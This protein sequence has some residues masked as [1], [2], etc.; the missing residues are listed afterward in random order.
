MTGMKPIHNLLTLSLS[1]FIMLGAQMVSGQF[2]VHENTTIH[3]DRDVS[4]NIKQNTF[5]SSIYGSA[6]LN[7][8]GDEQQ[9]LYAA[10]DVNL[11]D[12]NVLN[13]E[14]LTLYTTVTING[15]LNLEQSQVDILLPM[16]L[17]GNLNLD[18]LSGITGKHLISQPHEAQPY[19]MP[20]QQTPSKT[21]VLNADKP[22]TIS[23]VD[24][25]PTSHKKKYSLYQPM[26][27]YSI[28]IAVPTPP[29]E[30]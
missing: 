30:I 16:L 3:I 17:N 18:V 2:Y 7:F 27:A 23:V 9:E 5:N 15:D 8:S 21:S 13:V 14:L 19:K 28:S 12:V 24:V 29:P 25:L 10:D 4:T 11:P 22:I 6:E 26:F 1:A 20:W